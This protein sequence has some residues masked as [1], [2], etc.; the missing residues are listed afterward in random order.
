[1]GGV[2]LEVWMSLG[3]AVS[4]GRVREAFTNAFKD[5]AFTIQAM[6]QALHSSRDTQDYPKWHPF[7]R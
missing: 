3:E 4:E 7:A 2:R 6:I 1:M 5:H